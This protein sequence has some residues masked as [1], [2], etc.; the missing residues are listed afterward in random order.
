MRYF[1]CV[2][3]FFFALILRKLSGHGD[4][5]PDLAPIHLMI[6]KSINVAVDIV[7]IN[8]FIVKRLQTIDE[9]PPNLFVLR[10]CQTFVMQGELDT[11]FEDFVEGA[12]AVEGQDED[13]IVIL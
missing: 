7:E 12:D 11:Q 5:I 6:S 4:G 8:I 1:R 10:E 13:A 3:D 2:Y 9:I